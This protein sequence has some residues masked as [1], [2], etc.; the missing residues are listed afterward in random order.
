MRIDILTVFPEMFAPMDA[1]IVKRAREKDL[2]QLHIT[3]IRSFAL[4]KHAMTDDRLYGGGAG[5]ACLSSA[6]HLRGCGSGKRAGRR[7]RHN[8]SDYH[9][10]RRR[11]I[12]ADQGCGIGTG[13][14]GD[15]YLRAL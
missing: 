5:M 10:P 12:Y 4:D 15:F 8:Q 3:D 6:K 14:A 13:R 7:A 11:I 2:V 9:K 1:S